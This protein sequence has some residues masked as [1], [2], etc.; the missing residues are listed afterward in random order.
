MLKGQT[1]EPHVECPFCGGV[2]MQLKHSKN[3]NY[4]VS[5]KCGAVGPSSTSPDI[6]VRRWDH[7]VV[8]TDLSMII[9][10]GLA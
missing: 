4:F 9:G 6:A 10:G 8:Q 2:R 5:C 1:I 3:W 7:R